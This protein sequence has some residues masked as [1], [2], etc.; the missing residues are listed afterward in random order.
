MIKLELDH[1]DQV[2]LFYCL[3]STKQMIEES[4]ILKDGYRTVLNKWIDQLIEDL[5]I[6][7]EFIE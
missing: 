3:L 2:N 7:G 6:Q 1:I 5:K 4:N